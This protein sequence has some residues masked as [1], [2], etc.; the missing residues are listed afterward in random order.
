MIGGEN[1]KSKASKGRFP[2]NIR[3]VEPTGIRDLGAAYVD[4]FVTF[5][6][7]L[8][9]KE[10]VNKT[11]PEKIN[12][13]LDAMQLFTA[14][15]QRRRPPFDE[16]E[17]LPIVVQFSD[18]IVRIQP[19]IEGNDEVDA[20]DLF[21][22]ELSSILISQGNLACNGIL[23]RGGITF[24]SVCVHGNRIFG[25]AFNRAYQL[26]SSLA[27]YPRIVVDEVLCSSSKDN[28]IIQ[29]SSGDK[30]NATMQYI[31]EFI[32]RSEDGQWITNYLPNLVDAE[33]DSEIT[34]DDVLIAHRDSIRRLLTDATKAKNEGVIA[35]VR[36]AATYHNKLI[37]RAYQRINDRL[38][39][40]GTSLIVELDELA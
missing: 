34:R 29:K 21:Y 2:V 16:K 40:G 38:E 1:M 25:P 39:D 15:P 6:D 5:I 3:E 33:R 13:L 18:S 24:G 17:Y 11:N 28:P 23:I 7:L 26:E 19:I 30:W 37:S 32:D 31:F 20:V 27:I 9:F 10:I 22:E 4:A 36:W 35:K 14:M 8:G 12:T